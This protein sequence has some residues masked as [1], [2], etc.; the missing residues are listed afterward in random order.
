MKKIL[1]LSTLTAFV[2]LHAMTLKELNNAT[3][4]QLMSVSGIG[5]T[6]ADEIIKYRK[7]TPFKTFKEVE[8]VKGIGP[9]LAE[10][11]KTAKIKK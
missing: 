1:L 4:E 10:K 7:K 5:E 6:K 9:A 2:S 8:E 3:K 11:L